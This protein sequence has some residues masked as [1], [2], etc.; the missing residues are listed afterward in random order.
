[1]EK[2]EAQ[3]RIKINKLLEKSDWR[4]IDDENWKANISLEQW[5]SIHSV[6]DDFENV[7]KGYIDYLLCD[8][9]NFP[10]CVLE[11]KR[12]SIHPLSA[13]EQARDY[14]LSKNARFIILSNGNAHY[15]WDI[16]GGNPEI[17]SEFPTPESFKHRIEYK[18]NP[19]WLSSEI[20]DENYLAPV[21]KLRPY[22]VWAIQAVQDSAKLWKTRYLLEMATG[23]GK[24]TTAWALCKLWLKTGNAKRILFLVDRIELE[25]QAVKAFKELFK[26]TYFVDTIKSWEWE[27]CQ[28]VVSTIQT[29]LVWDRYKEI[30]S[31]IDFELVISD[32][33]HR[34]IGWNSRAVFEYF[35]GYKLGLT[36]TP[37]DYLKGLEKE[38]NYEKNPKAMEIRNLRDTYKT[39]WC[40]AWEPTFRYDLKA[41][42][43]EGYLINPFVIDARTDITTELLSVEWYTYEWTDD[44]WN[45]VEDSFWARDFEKTFFNEKTNQ[46]FAQS[47]VDNLLLDPI[48]GEAWKTLVFCVSQN[49]ASKITN[50]LNEIAMKKYPW[51]YDSDFA[52]QVTSTVMNAQQYTKDFS[53][54]RLKGHSHFKDDIYPDYGTSKSRVCVT[55]GMMTTGYDC[56]DL[57][58]VVLLRPVF[59]PADFVQMKGRGTRK[60]TFLYQETWETKEKEQ[61]LLID[62]FWNCEYFEKDFDYHKKL[63]L[64]QIKW[65]KWPW[66]DEPPLPP[67]SEI[68]LNEFDKIC[69]E[70]TI[71]IGTEWMKIDRELYRKTTHEQF[72]FVVQK[73]ETIKKVY[74]ENWLDAVEDLIKNEVFNKPTE[75]WT[76]Q[77]IR[78]SYEREHRTGRI[79]P[80]KELLAKALGLI[81]KFSTREEKLES[82][83]QKFLT[84]EKI[85]FENTDTFELLKSLFETYLADESFRAIIDEWRFAE[86]SAYP[87]V[88]LEDI[89]RV[90][91]QAINS[92]KIYANEYLSSSMKEFS[93]VSK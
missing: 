32:E 79:L 47:I 74:E 45:A 86:L 3:S 48:T 52:L 76:P 61:F 69:T 37:K 7:S 64:P 8:E 46:V 14:A 49:H 44:D 57:L 11:A 77:K 71:Y 33:A 90:S 9:R 13:K 88:S 87:C 40:E 72:E 24:T 63:E 68:D 55:V 25:D 17:I 23:T 85:V 31:P 70:T 1:M 75:F 50:L 20:V 73:S 38:E 60:H 16:E 62:F 27:K 43:E 28:I 53:N 78:D 10:I 2:K 84:T 66:L 6:G 29:L 30:F 34:S 22:Q 81:T 91:P 51:I 80:L 83:W 35:I 18:P 4:F 19:I 54:N 92:V 5:T 59:S 39:F 42:V 36:A 41:W 12:E 67:P 65:E 93:L 21:K 56:P 89:R 26:D 82:E 15:L 58:N